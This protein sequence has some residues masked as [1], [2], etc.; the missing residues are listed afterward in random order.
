MQTEIDMGAIQMNTGLSLIIYAYIFF[1]YYL[2]IAI[3]E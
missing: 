2:A 1:K 3:I